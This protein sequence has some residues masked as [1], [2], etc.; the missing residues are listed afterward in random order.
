MRRILLT[1]AFLILYSGIANAQWLHIRVEKAGTDGESVKVNVPISL[2][3]TALPMV[4][5][6]HLDDDD[7]QIKEGKIKI[8]ESD[9]DIVQ[10]RKL[11]Q[12]LKTAGDFEVATVES[13]DAH[14]RVWLENGFVQVKTNEKDQAQVDIRVPMQVVDALLAGEG[15]ELDLLGAIKALGESGVEEVVSIRDGETTVRIW[16]NAE[17]GS[18]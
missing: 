12:E 9:I 11:W 6:G 10:L 7:L 17:S 14:V 1:A 8:Q 5:S 18:E 13:K 2:V 4:K 15:N 3:E 16:V